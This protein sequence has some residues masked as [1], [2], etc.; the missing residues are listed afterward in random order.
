M[1]IL[2]CLIVTSL[3]A[4]SVFAQTRTVEGT[5]KGRIYNEL[6]KRWI[7]TDI[8][9]YVDLKGNFYTVALQRVLQPRGMLPKEAVPV[10]ISA[11]EKSKEWAKKAKEG[12]VEITKSLGDFATPEGEILHDIKLSFFSIQKGKQTDVIMAVTDFDNE[13]R[14]AEVYIAT[15]DVDPLI[16]ILKKVDIAHKE[17]VEQKRKS[18]DF[19]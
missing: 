9:V 1:K 18:D 15:D 17:L 2:R 19:K 8:E 16:G 6:L 13:F 3:L 12:E 5:A 11:L 4:S 14:K 7:P 10:F